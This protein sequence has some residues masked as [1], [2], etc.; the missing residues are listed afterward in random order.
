MLCSGE[1][2]TPLY[3]PSLVVVGGSFLYPGGG[4]LTPRTTLLGLH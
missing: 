2:D 4:D 1:E 3:Q